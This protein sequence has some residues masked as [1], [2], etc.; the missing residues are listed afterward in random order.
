[1]EN[2]E[3]ALAEYTVQDRENK[4][5]GR[6][7]DEA[8]ELARSLVDELRALLTGYDWKAVLTAG[9]PKA[10]LNAV[11]GAVNYLRD[12]T[13]PGNAPTAGEE[14]LAARY[15]RFSGQLARVSGSCRSTVEA[16]GELSD[17]HRAM[18]GQHPSSALEQAHPMQCA[19][20][21]LGCGL[22]A[23]ITKSCGERGE[24][25][26]QLGFCIFSGES[27]VD[28]QLEHCLIKRR[29]GGRETK[30]RVSDG[31]DSPRTR[32]ASHGD[33]CRR[34]Q[35]REPG[36]RHCA[37]DLGLAAGE[38]RID[39]GL[40]VADRVSET[41][42]GDGRPTVRLGRGARRIEDLLSAFGDALYARTRLDHDYSCR[43]A[44]RHD[45]G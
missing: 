26:T 22:G 37:E 15:R 7:V 23:A 13:T 3:K 16:G 42:Q 41:P 33:P 10:Y 9:G 45:L 18:F 24:A 40:R 25:S 34:R 21:H 6:N 17:S 19:P 30:V 27:G 36:K 2:L 38:V 12:V 29:V 32:L 28:R 31:R 1:V 43:F 39:D 20:E 5:I 35:L 11:T 8:V 4:P 14:T 44:T